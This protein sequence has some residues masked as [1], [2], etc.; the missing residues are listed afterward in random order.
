MEYTTLISRLRT[1]S[2]S[3]QTLE[4]QLADPDVANDPKKLES[5]ARE[6]AKLEPLVIDFKKLLNIDKEIEDSKILLKNNRNDKEMETLI[7]EELSSLEEL[8][9]QLIQKTTI[10]LLPKDPRD[11][12]V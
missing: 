2:E 1:A 10:A 3:F 6:R 9:I 4:L 11:E 7:N 12:E 8:K 5:I